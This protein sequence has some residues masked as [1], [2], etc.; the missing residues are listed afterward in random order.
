MNRVVH[1]EIHANDTEKV[2]AFYRDVFGWTVWKWDNPKFDYWV[3]MTGSDNSKEPGIDGGITKREHPA[4]KGE[5]V[6]S[7]TIAV[8]SIDE[9]VKKIEAAGG[10]NV[11]PKIAIPGTSWIAYCAD[12]EGNVF[13]LFEADENAK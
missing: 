3:V 6:T 13:G 9:Y 11:V 1:F 5:P 8:S 4:Q 7:I 10:R 2:A 12:I